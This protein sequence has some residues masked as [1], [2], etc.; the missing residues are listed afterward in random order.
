MATEL[1]T[2]YL[3]LVPSASGMKGKI[4][5]E[6]GG[7]GSA[8]AVHTEGAF[9]RSA[10]RA[11]QA[12]K[13]GLKA[14][15]AAGAA[16]LVIGVASAKSAIESASNLNEAQTKVNAI[17]G[18]EGQAK[19]DAWAAK[20]AMAF[21]QSKLA[22]TDAIGTYG[23]LF[24]SFGVGKKRALEMS[25]T[26][27]GLA[28]D[29]ASFNNTSVAD[30][31][32]ALRSGLSGE[33]EPLKRYG[34]AIDDVSLKAKAAQLGL[35][36]STVDQGKLIAAQTALS[37]AQQ[38]AAKM[39][40]L[41]GKGSQEFADAQ[42]MV[43]AAQLKLG[44]VM[45]GKFPAQLTPAQR[46]QAAYALVLER[47]KNAQGDF[48]RTSGGLAN[49]QRIFAARWENLKATIGKGLLPVINR[50][51]PVIGG[52]FDKIGPVA[53]K[54]A[55]KISAFFNGFSKSKGMADG[56]QRAGVILGRVRTVV[57]TVV[58]TVKQ[59]W[60]QIRQTIGEVMTTVRTIIAGV[61]DVILTLWRNF[62][63]NIL[64]FAKR[65][66][67]PLRQIVSGALE[68]IRGVIKTITSL[69]HGDWKG[70]WDGLKSIVHGAFN[71]IIGSVKYFLEQ[72]R[73]VLGLLLEVVGSIF[74]K[75]WRLAWEATKDGW[76]VVARYFTETIPRG[77]RR[78]A[79][80]IK[81]A[82]LAPFKSAFRAIAGL[83]NATIG[84]LSFK[85]PSWVPK[86]GGKGFSFPKIDEGQFDKF[87][88]GGVYRAPS[89]GGE[90]LAL[91]KDGERVLSPQQTRAYDAG[92]GAGVHF[93][94]PVT[95]G[96]N[97]VSELDYWA[98]KIARDRRL[99]MG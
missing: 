86:I 46:A 41:H 27:T 24:T 30:A 99:V 52:L 98:R 16:A 80:I 48:S 53:E 21:G 13:T 71:I 14:A 56:A 81:N 22:A 54:Y 51:M 90:G 15:G 9:K 61:V 34:I 1:A 82:L 93:H 17:F 85:I 25:T 4:E 26:M 89:A 33:T 57:E 94:G 65:V 60:P 38:K 79:G 40:A 18:A 32:D 2:A 29:L 63:D 42:A 73:V 62:G 45:A 12:F 66:W 23:N 96:S 37:K 76:G 50:L 77:L 8:A 97:V 78:L 91:L 74:K 55:P 47:T 35:I 92:M 10:G 58:T 69:I 72:V 84:K 59:R 43:T 87:H 6:L 83:W 39:Q 67:G 88:Q 36:K 11:S 64:T 28:S 7:A 95:F 75:A 31:I 20:A 19:V 68:V 5:R 70:V 3:S 49:Q 44:D